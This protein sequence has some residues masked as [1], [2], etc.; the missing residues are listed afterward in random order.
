MCSPSVD[1]LRSGGFEEDDGIDGTALGGFVGVVAAA[2]VDTDAAA[3]VGVWDLRC[4]CWSFLVCRN[5]A[6]GASH[7]VM[8]MVR[9]ISPND[10]TDSGRILVKRRFLVGEIASR[11]DLL[12]TK[13][14]EI[15]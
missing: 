4:C 1:G 13:E 14:E 8:M 15:Y 11:L 6:G 3:V 10:G 12:S 2:D 9:M 7:V 5:C